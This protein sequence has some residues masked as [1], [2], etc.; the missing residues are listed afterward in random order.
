MSAE[1]S[2]EARASIGEKL[3]IESPPTFE[4][5]LT[6]D[7]A[8]FELALRPWELLCRPLARG[9]FRHTV[10]ALRTAEFILYRERFDMPVDVIGISPKDTVVLGAPITIGR[11]AYY[12]H[13]PYSDNILPS[14]LPGP[15]DVTLAAGHFHQV[16]VVNLTFL[17]ASLP[18]EVLDRLLATIR[19][20]FV[21]VPENVMRRYLAWGRNLLH[22]AEQDPSVFENPSVVATVREELLQHL[23]CIAG[24]LTPVCDRSGYAPRS[25]GLL[26]VLESMRHDLTGS[27]RMAEL[28]RVA[29]ISERSLQYAF[30]ETFNMTP[31]QFMKRRRLHAVRQ[32]LVTENENTATVT[33]LA[34]RHG[35]YELGRFSV[36]YRR[37]F[38]EFPSASLQRVSFRKSPPQ[39]DPFF[40]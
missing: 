33:Q 3:A 32:A 36:E 15:L 26:K 28:C 6:R 11:G 2:F 40:G 16:A 29:G 38:G 21:S 24:Q 13:T 39:G 30:R 20:R 27:F 19:S 23:S 14:S 10:K 8:E 4:E 35:F 9:A 1:E 34:T 22:I 7:P 25:R 17:R 12:W 5:L 18:E 37:L 31:N